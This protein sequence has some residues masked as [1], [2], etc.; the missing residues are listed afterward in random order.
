MDAPE[1]IV[2]ELERARRLERLHPAPLRIQRRE[3][4]VDDAVFPGRIHPLQH[5][6]KR[7]LPLGVQVELKLRQL[8]AVPGRLLQDFVVLAEPERAGGIDPAQI[9]LL[10]R[11][12]HQ[13][14]T[15]IH[16]PPSPVGS[17]SI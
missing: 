17:S 2:R 3:N 15:Q 13:L 9:D 12:D 14:F 16:S 10:P 6:E 1:E 8:G 5:D 4:V 7:A 11:T